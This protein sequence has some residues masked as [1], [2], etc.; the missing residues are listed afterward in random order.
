MAH[1][2]T[3]CCIGRSRENRH[4]QMYRGNTR[5]TMGCRTGRG[6][7]TIRRGDMAGSSARSA[8]CTPR[9]NGMLSARLAANF[10][11]RYDGYAEATTAGKAAGFL[12]YR[13]QPKHAV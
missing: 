9:E 11:Y 7:P 3:E 4:D 5:R 12:R 6:F 2:L 8:P 1:E 10:G 13:R